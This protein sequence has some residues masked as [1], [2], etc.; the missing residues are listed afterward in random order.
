MVVVYT[1]KQKTK[2]PPSVNSGGIFSNIKQL[3]FS[4]IFITCNVTLN[5]MHQK[6]RTTF[7]YGIG[8]QFPSHSIFISLKKKKFYSYLILTDLETN[9][10]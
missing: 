2:F 6:F 7:S 8:W 10:Y 4:N 5:D 9:K 3:E 1:S